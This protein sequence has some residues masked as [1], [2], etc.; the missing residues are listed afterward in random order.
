MRSS[1]QKYGS[2]QE[3]SIWHRWVY[4]N[5]MGNIPL[6]AYLCFLLLE[7]SQ[8]QTE[9]EN[10]ICRQ[11]QIYINVYSCLLC[12]CIKK[13]MTTCWSF[14]CISMHLAALRT[15]FSSEEIPL[16]CSCHNLKSE[17][18]II[19]V[20]PTYKDAFF[21]LSNHQRKHNSR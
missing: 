10:W 5:R 12:F 6:L 13:I 16:L 11:K 14:H 19:I 4:R 2:K 17:Y 18:I 8:G 9:N 21:W 20:W 1:A 15:L 3:M 7:T